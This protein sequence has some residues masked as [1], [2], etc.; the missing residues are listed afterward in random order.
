MLVNETPP[1]I[2]P[3]ACCQNIKLRDATQTRT[4]IRG[5]C[6]RGPPAV[7]DIGVSSRPCRNCGVTAS[8]AVNHQVTMMNFTVSPRFLPHQSIPGSVSPASRCWVWIRPCL[9]LYW[10]GFMGVSSAAWTGEGCVYTAMCV[11]RFTGTWV[12]TH[13]SVK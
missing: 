4:L 2:T 3:T 7:L 1:P 5:S 9:C 10:R 8:G 11:G 6:S 12:Y 13:G